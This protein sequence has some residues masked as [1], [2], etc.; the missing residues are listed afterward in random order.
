MQVPREITV[1]KKK[2]RKIV[3]LVLV[4]RYLSLQVRMSIFQTLD[5]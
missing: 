5:L 2:D 3:E 1:T 4:T